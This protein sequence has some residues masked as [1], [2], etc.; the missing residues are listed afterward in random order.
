M[1]LWLEVEAQRP[2]AFT[3]VA[4]EARSEMQIEGI[5]VR[6]VVDRIDELAD[7]R[8]VIL[9]YKTGSAISQA[10]WGET[11]IREPQLP[12][13]AALRQGGEGEALAEAAEIAAVAFAK[14]RPD[15][16]S[17]IG[18]AADADILPNVNGIAD[19]GARKLFPEQANWNELLD[20]WRASIAAIA[21]EI[22][23]G[24]AAVSFSDEKDLDYCEVR[25][26]LRL[27]ERKAQ[28]ES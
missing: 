22:K 3:V 7:G 2:Q 17:F 14:V 23:A 25:P 9:D 27:A 26:L 24:E 19:G 15:E 4:C 8:R 21:R 10:S 20:H 13:Y 1:G 11:R 5:A 28:L 6:L 16:C 18:I 12:I